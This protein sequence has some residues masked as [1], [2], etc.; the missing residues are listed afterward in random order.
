[1]A[2]AALIALAIGSEA[3][4]KMKGG[5]TMTKPTTMTGTMTGTMPSTMTGMMK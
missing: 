5:M 4:A 1:M 2:V 3:M